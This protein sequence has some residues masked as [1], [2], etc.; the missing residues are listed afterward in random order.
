MIRDLTAA[1]GRW[2]QPGSRQMGEILIRAVERGHELRHVADI[3]RIDLVTNVRAEEA[4]R[5]ALST[6]TGDYRP[7][8]TAPNLRRGW[9]LELESLP[10]VRRA[11][12]LF[13]PAMLGVLLDFERGQ[14]PTTSLR[15][16]LAR[17]T[18]MYAVTRKLSD[19]D[20]QALIGSFCRS[21]DGCLKTIL[22]RICPD[23]AVQ[24]LPASKFDPG[25]Q[26]ARDHA[27]AP[28][29][30]LCHEA[31]NLL[32]AKAREVVKHGAAD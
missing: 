32:V 7:L 24:T 27:A 30:M 31:C 8:K 14:L 18:G 10:E 17:Q 3:H 26:Q 1:L 19:Q 13:Y 12:D 11:L 23:T 9:R 4:R 20:A 16:T 22:W 29:P 28:L 2:L 25:V 5:I 21:E 6:A 15:E